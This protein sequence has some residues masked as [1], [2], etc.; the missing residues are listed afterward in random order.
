VSLV[1][2]SLIGLPWTLLFIVLSALVALVAGFAADTFVKRGVLPE[3]PNRTTTRTELSLGHELTNSLR[4]IHWHPR[5]V[6]KL[7]VTGIRESK[8]LLRWILLGVILASLLRVWVS[9]ATF[10]TWFGATWIGLCLT[11]IATTLIE[12]CS[13][14]SSPLAADLLHRGHAPGNAFAFLMGGV[15]TD[16]TEMMVLRQ[17]TGSWKLALTLPLVTVPQVMVLG[18]WINHLSTL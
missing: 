15:A 2:I 16:Y 4:T 9:D 17:A 11:M 10:S 7:L 3:N 18:W 8:M 1:L 5:L 14:G 13:E 12:V 6:I